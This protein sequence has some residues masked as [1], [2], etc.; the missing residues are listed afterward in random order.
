[1]D[2]GHLKTHAWHELN[3]QYAHMSGAEQYDTASHAANAIE[4]LLNQ[5]VVWTTKSVSLDT[6]KNAL[7][8]M[9]AIFE[10][11]CLS[12]GLTAHEVRKNCQGWDNKLLDV[13][14]VLSDAELDEIVNADDG[15]WLEKFR[16]VV[17]LAADISILDGLG[18][19]L[20]ILEQFD[21]FNE[22]DDDYDEDDDSKYD[23]DYY[24]DF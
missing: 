22:Y 1:M 24:A 12:G 13:L 17:D 16:E 23:E 19:G 6:K 3:S 14:W 21:A 9:R 11:R 7:E 5:I 2:F 4:G 20:E 15:E 8:T 18:E 10:T